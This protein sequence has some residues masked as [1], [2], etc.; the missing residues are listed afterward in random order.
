M[1]FPILYSFKRCPYAMRARMA[2]KLANVR[3]EIR[4]IRLNNKPEHMLE[5][6]PK[7]TV[8]VLILEDKIIDESIEIIEWVLDQDNVFEGNLNQNEVVLSEKLISIFDEKFKYHLDRY[9]YAARYNNVNSDKNRS[10][11]ME[12][13]IE[14]NQIISNKKWIFGESINKLDISILPFIRQFRIADPEWFDMQ[15]SIHSVK[16]VLNNFLESE[17]LNEIMIN[18]D[19]W[20]EGSKPEYFP[21]FNLSD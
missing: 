16:R 2:I 20:K 1:K 3:C 17:L 9:K 7:G 13:L 10:Q 5:A 21:I 19:E 6:S 12:I 4:E 18:Y 15:V 11:C 8:P 14:L